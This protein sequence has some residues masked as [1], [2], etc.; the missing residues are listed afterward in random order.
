MLDFPKPLH[1]LH[2]F[3]KDGRLYAADLDKAQHV[4]ISPLIADIL[5]LAERQTAEEI[6]HNPNIVAQFANTHTRK[7]LSSS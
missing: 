2:I 3:E 7:D 5:K 1:Q 6:T 4:E